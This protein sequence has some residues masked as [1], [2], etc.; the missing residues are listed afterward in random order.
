M[1]RP[2]TK[3]LKMI[4]P[5]M[6]RLIFMI[7]L[8]P[9][10][11]L[12]H[13]PVDLEITNSNWAQYATSSLFSFFLFSLLPYTWLLIPE[14]E[15][16]KYYHHLPG[17][18]YRKTEAGIKIL[19]SSCHGEWLSHLFLSFPNSSIILQPI[20]KGMGNILIVAE[21]TSDQVLYLKLWW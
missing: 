17:V 21:N 15:D 8:F 5:T 9:Y 2:P 13:L 11:I 18:T 12:P 6:V 19:S 4:K 1:W 16:R 7:F 20:C 14:C 10:S 3:L